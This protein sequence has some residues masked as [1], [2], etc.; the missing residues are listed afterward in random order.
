MFG[1]KLT[2][3][4]PDPSSK[5]EKRQRISIEGFLS[6]LGILDKPPCRLETSHVTAS[7]TVEPVPVPGSCGL[8]ASAALGFVNGDGGI[9]ALGYQ[10]EHLI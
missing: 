5:G 8:R 3:T 7:S 9:A 1:R 10:D 6:R 4:T 2:K